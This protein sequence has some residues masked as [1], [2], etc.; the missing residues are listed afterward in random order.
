MHLTVTP[1]VK[2]PLTV[3][4]SLTLCIENL[5]IGRYITAL[6]ISKLILG[7]KA[8]T[9]KCSCLVISILCH[10]SKDTGDDVMKMVSS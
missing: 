8:S 2:D 5:K 9:R 6:H 10:F 4:I 7:H 3:R 1:T